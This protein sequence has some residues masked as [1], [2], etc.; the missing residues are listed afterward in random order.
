MPWSPDA[1]PQGQPRQ[2]FSPGAYRTICVRSCDGY[3][4]PISGSTSRGQFRKDAESCSARCSGGKLY[5]APRDSEDMAAMVDLTGR[6]YDQLDRAFVYRKKLIDGCACRPMPW[7][8]AERARHN[9]YAYAEEILRLNEDR[10]RQLREPAV[11]RS[12]DPSGETAGA[13]TGG[14]IPQENA[15]A[16]PAAGG[17]SPEDGTDNAAMSGIRAAIANAAAPGAELADRQGA[18]AETVSYSPRPAANAR[19]ISDTKPRRDR[20]TRRKSSSANGW[21]FAG[22]GKYTWPGDR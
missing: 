3:Y 20:K 22:G 19:A 13:Q 1:D 14:D 6:R 2:S 7:T 12:A 5:Y 16:G 15:D 21:P 9:R 18:V 4:F 8:A 11:A 10:A 17:A